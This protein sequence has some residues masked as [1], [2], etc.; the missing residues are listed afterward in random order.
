MKVKRK[1][2]SQPS[3]CTRFTGISFQAPEK[4]EKQKSKRQPSKQPMRK[5]AEFAIILKGTEGKSEK[6]E[7]PKSQ[8]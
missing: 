7:R 3:T 4:V 8:K 5:T 1:L 2:R 6:I